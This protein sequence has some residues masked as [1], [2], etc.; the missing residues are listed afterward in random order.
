MRRLIGELGIAIVI[1]AFVGG[2]VALRHKGYLVLR[3]EKP[4]GAFSAPGPQN[5]SAQ[6]LRREAAPAHRETGGFQ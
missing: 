6:V 5:G 2:M 1:G 4:A 3:P